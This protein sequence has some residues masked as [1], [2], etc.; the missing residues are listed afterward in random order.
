M[1][2]K[3]TELSDEWIRLISLLDILRGFGGLQ[4]QYE[5]Y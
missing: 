2:Y 1:E 4:Y 3:S 5:E